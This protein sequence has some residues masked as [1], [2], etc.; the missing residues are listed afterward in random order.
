MKNEWRMLSERAAIHESGL[1]VKFEQK[2]LRWT[3]RALNAETWILNDPASKEEKIVRLLHEALLVHDMH[4]S[5][6]LLAPPKK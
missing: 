3:A 1:V 5:Y 2:N 6:A 4:L